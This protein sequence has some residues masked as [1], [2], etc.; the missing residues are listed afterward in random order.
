MQDV[1]DIR[2]I[3]EKHSPHH[4]TN[5]L[6]LLQTQSFLEVLIFSIQFPHKPHESLLSQAKASSATYLLSFKRKRLVKCKNLA[7]RDTVEIYKCHQVLCR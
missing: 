3:V 7:K 5:W 2:E 1:G 4:Y 6:L